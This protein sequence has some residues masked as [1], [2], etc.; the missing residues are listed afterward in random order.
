VPAFAGVLGV[1]AKTEGKSKTADWMEWVAFEVEAAA[2]MWD[3]EIVAVVG[4]ESY[5]LRVD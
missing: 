2:E 1:E 3:V 4:N 5:A